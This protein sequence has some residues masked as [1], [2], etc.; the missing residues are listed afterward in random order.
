MGSYRHITSAT[1]L[2]AVILLSGCGIFQRS[3]KKDVDALPSWND[4]PAKQAIVRFVSDTSDFFSDNFI[5]PGDRIAVFDDDG[6]LWPERPF[7]TAVG[8]IVHRIREMA[9]DHPEWSAKEPFSLVLGGGIGSLSEEQVLILMEKAHGGMTQEDFSIMAERWV[10]TTEHPRFDRPYRQLAYH[11]MVELLRYLERSG[12]RVYVTTEG[13]VEFV[14]AFSE[15][16]FGIPRERVMGTV[17]AMDYEE[18]EFGSILNRRGTVVD[19]VNRAEGKPVNIQRFAGGRPV[20]VFG[21]SDSDLPM[22]EFSQSEFL[23]SLSLFLAHDDPEREYV[24]SDKTGR[25]RE[26]VADRGW[27]PVSMKKDFR[28]IFTPEKNRKKD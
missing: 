17:T 28:T 18:T 21:N 11:P 10:R 20:L 5:P 7:R 25:V 4:G 8:F 14:R 1:V 12:F 6:T 13:D 16:V 3:A 22:I 27:V 2:V 9:G 26:M 19:P 15:V 24:Y 23:P